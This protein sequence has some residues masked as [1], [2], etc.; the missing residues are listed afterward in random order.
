M[1]LLKYLRPFVGIQGIIYCFKSV[2][3]AHLG[4]SRCIQ[5]L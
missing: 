4:G 2:L 5:H 3:N 1:I